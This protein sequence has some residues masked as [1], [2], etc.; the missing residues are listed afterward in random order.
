[1]EI[2]NQ[3]VDTEKKLLILGAHQDDAEFSC[4]RLLL[5]RKGVN[6]HIIYFTD[7]KMGQI[8]DE[9]V[10]Q[11]DHAN[12][13]KIESIKAMNKFGV[14]IDKLIF[15]DLPD[16]DL[17]SFP[18][19]IDKLY[20]LFKK[21]Q[22]DFILIPPFEGAH[23]DHDVVHLFS[24]IAA[25][26]FKIKKNKIIE[27]SS[28][29]NYEGKF[30]IQE[31]IPMDTHEEK[32]IPTDEEQHRWEEIMKVFESQP[33]LHEKYVPNSSFESFRLLPNYDYSN[34]P[35]STKI[36]NMIRGLLFPIYPKIK[37]Y[38][39]KKYK[40]FYET[41]ENEVNPSKILKSLKKYDKEYEF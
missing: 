26:N 14:S 37:K 4:G 28:Y 3:L 11:K 40:L 23:P 33:S 10:S 21:I 24:T 20:I 29:N 5:K 22:P 41:W 13:R 12:I 25:R 27:Y 32:L 7:G 17:I 39:P 18:Y 36:S 1:M 38:L 16:Q 8:D 30:R 6:S 2:I 31:F 34:L 35:Y 19:I 15:L 9:K